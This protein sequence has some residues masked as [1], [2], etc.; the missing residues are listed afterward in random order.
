MARI[1]SLDRGA[2]RGFSLIEVLIAVVVLSVGLLALGALQ[3]ALVRNSS[4]TK[5]RSG[6]LA[7][8][9]EHLEN[10]RSFRDRAQYDE[11]ETEELP[12]LLYDADVDAGRGGVDYTRTTQVNHYAF[13]T[14]TGAFEAYNSDN[15]D[16]Y[17]A[18]REFK[19]VVVDV[20]WKDA[21]S[22]VDRRVQVSDFVSASSPQEAAQ[23][24]RPRSV[25]NVR[26]RVLITNPA[27]EE[28]VIPVAI[29]NNT[30][31]AATN[32]RPEV[33]GRNSDLRVIE[34][35]FDVLTYR[36]GSNTSNAEV[37]ARVETVIVGC[38][39]AASPSSAIG[40]RPSYWDG[41]R[42][43]R[44]VSTGAAATAQHAS[45]SNSDP[46][47]SPLCTEC[48]RDHHD[49]GFT[50]PKFSPR[51]SSH[52]H[53]IVGGEYLEACRM[54]RVDG[55]FH[56]AA[57]MYNDYFNLLETA[58]TSADPV[59]AT[60][61]ADNYEGLVLDYL[62]G[63]MVTGSAYNTLPAASV[64]TGLETVHDI[65]A[66]AEIQIDRAGSIKW[67]HGRGLYV[68]YL[69]DSAVTRLNDAK[70]DCDTG[71]STLA[72]CVLR[73]VPFTSINL[74][75]L[76]NWLPNSGTEIVVTNN[77]F[78]SSI[79]AND[80]VRGRVE[81]VNATPG[82][83]QTASGAIWNS[84]AGL[85]L[86]IPQINDESEMSDSQVFKVVGSNPPPGGG[87]T[88]TF[89]ITISGYP[90]GASANKIPGFSFVPPETG[91]I[92]NHA[93]SGTTA[94]NPYTCSSTRLDGGLSMAVG[95]YNYQFNDTYASVTCT[96]SNGSSPVSCPN[97]TGPKC[98][99][100]TVDSAMVGSTPGVVGTVSNEGKGTES[101]ALQFANVSP[102]NALTVAF[103]EGTPSLATCTYTG[104]SSQAC[105]A[106]KQ[107]WSDPCL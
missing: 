92:C 11:I 64:V 18:G 43:T 15:A 104:N 21:Q 39:C 46:P 54:I 6:A 66:P 10:L 84:N 24:L 93:T 28:G 73:H 29:G 100:W 106:S 48:C 30:D 32:P 60:T 8:A 38:T 81:S 55:I 7:L 75:E 71:T 33:A 19:Q 96:K 51:R 27:L 14:E 59:P 95:N 63:R 74:T 40:F 65:N 91:N 89:S 62:G 41:T 49:S 67:L 68:D 97:V 83:N 52:T 37:Q 35:R 78:A 50:G 17:V 44:P 1:Y 16:K 103:S 36:A 45:L 5:A 31:T 42:Y 85:A 107:S 102:G 12:V 79:T 88:G 20:T 105:N 90:L 9:E 13:N 70:T 87:T 26:P 69:E 82:T 77:D 61:A 53:S 58:N 99:N 80:P 23:V 94:P 4:E 72:A 76:A 98:R 22:D 25:G 57:D 3:A 47:E 34:T 2:A 56:T 101:T 86:I